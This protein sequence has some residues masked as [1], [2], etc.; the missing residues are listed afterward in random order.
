MENIAC[1]EEIRD[2]YKILFGKIGR[3]DS[4]LKT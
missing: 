1:V 2:R 3:K 4:T